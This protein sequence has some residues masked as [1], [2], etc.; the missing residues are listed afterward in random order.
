LLAWGARKMTGVDFGLHSS[1]APWIACFSALAALIPAIR[2]SLRWFR[3]WR[4]PKALIRADLDAGTVEE[5]RLTFTSAKRFQE[6]EHGG[7]IYFLRTKKGRAFV[8]FDHESQDLGVTGKDPLSSSF[9][10]CVDLLIARAPATR[11]VLMRSFSGQPLNIESPTELTAPP[12]NWPEQDEF[13]DIPW[14]QLE[15]RLGHVA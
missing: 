7:L 3:S 8:V 4:D 10:P 13:C 11:C 1:I 5:E 6:P 2:S 15:N 12:D 14:A 9:R